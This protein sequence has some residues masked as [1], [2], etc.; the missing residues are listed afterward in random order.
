MLL[1][2][3]YLCLVMLQMDK[4]S[5]LCNQLNQKYTLQTRIQ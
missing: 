2:I 4:F 1:G 5:F 3:I